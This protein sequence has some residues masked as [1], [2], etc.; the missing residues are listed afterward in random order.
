MDKL[1]ITLPYSDRKEGLLKERGLNDNFKNNF[2]TVD[3][4][5]TKLSEFS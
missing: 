3:A 5:N 2:K 1:I 4:V